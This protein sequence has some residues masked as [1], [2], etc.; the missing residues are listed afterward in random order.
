MNKKRDQYNGWELKFF[1]K[2]KNFRNYQISL[3]KKYLGEY[4]GI[5]PETIKSL[6]RK[7]KS[8]KKV[9]EAPFEGLVECVG[10]QK[11]KLL[12]THLKD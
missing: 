8:V 10:L 3:I 9:K 4:K 2:S 6:M 12:Q 7:Y 5:G 1:D 11:A